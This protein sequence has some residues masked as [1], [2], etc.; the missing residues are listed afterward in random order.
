LDE[1]KSENEK[2]IDTV[3][4]EEVRCGGEIVVIC[5]H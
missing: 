3:R 2:E 5:E 4:V 1:E